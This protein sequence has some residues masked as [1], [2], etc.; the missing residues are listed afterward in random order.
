MEHFYKKFRLVKNNEKTLI[1]RRLIMVEGKQ[2][3]IRAS[4]LKI[5]RVQIFRPESKSFISVFS[6][7]DTA[8]KVLVMILW[9]QLILST[10]QC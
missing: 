2:V 6:K 10:H 8:V 4:E 9:F 1:P 3:Q 5:W 7:L